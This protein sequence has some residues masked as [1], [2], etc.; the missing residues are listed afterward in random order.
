MKEQITSKKN[1]ILIAI[2]YIFPTI[3][4]CVYGIPKIIETYNEYQDEQN[5]DL[6]NII[7]PI[8]FFVLANY[9]ITKFLDKFPVLTITRNGIEFRFFLK[10]KNIIGMKLRILKL[11]VKNNLLNFLLHQLKQQHFI[12]KTKQR[13]YFG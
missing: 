1:K 12:L 13:K 9:L 11:R 3:I 5:S 10:Q 4:F 7:L 2:L 6:T 8:L